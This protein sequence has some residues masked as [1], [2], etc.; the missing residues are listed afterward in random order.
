[1]LF[2]ENS[3]RTKRLRS[4]QSVLIRVICGYIKTL[5][6]NPSVLIRV[7]CGKK[8]IMKRRNFIQLSSLLG[9]LGII[10][11][12]KLAAA[13]TATNEDDKN[14]N[15]RKYWVQLLAKISAP[16]SIEYEQRRI[17][18]KYADGIQSYLGQP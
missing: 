18:K 11:A 2:R 13:D 12:T 7:I 4:N 14:S 10:P 8:K 6:S 15:D 16:V 9:F 17:E 3:W 1:M 5:R